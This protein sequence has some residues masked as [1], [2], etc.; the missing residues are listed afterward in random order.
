MYLGAGLQVNEVSSCTAMSCK[1]FGNKVS[2]LLKIRVKMR[3]ALIHLEAYSE[4][5]YN[6]LQP[7]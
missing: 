3:Q 1:P 6:S 7:C 5:L 2:G 4:S